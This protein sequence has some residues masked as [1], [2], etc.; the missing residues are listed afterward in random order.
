M[1]ISLP[2]TLKTWVE[3]QVRRKGFAT[4]SEYVRQVLGRERHIEIVRNRVDDKLI[5]ALES[6]PIV[7]MTRQD[8]DEIWREAEQ[9]SAGKRRE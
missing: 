7:E 4:A 1:N 3:Q 5:A 8:W 9:R 2:E 6:G